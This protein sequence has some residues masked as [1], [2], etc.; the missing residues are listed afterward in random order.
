VIP[1]RYQLALEP[2]GPL[3][4]TPG[5]WLGAAIGISAHFD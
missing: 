1:T 5:L 4:K 3:G 2:T